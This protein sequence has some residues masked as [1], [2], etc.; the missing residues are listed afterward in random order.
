MTLVDSTLDV[1]TIRRDF[2]V[3]THPKNEGL[4]YLDSAATTQKPDVVIEAMNDF[5]R[6]YN[7]NTHRG[8]YDMAERATN[9]FEGARSK[10]AKFIH[11]PSNEQIIFTRGTTE[12]INLVA[13]GWADLHV[14]EGDR[15]VISEME[16]HSNI[17]PWQMV[18]KRRGAELVYW[19]FE[20]DGTLDV[21]KLSDLLTDRTRL[22]SVTQISNALGTI[23]PLPEIIALAHEKGVPVAVDGAQGVAHQPVDVQGLDVDFY[24]FSGHKMVGPTGI[25]VLYA[26]KERLNEMQPVMFGGDM[27]ESVDYQESTWNELPYR[28]EGG[29]QNIAGAIGLGAAIDYLSAIGLEVIRDYEAELTRYALQ[30]LQDIDD[31]RI[32]G[33]LENR[34]AAISFTLGQIHA[35]DLATWLDQKKIAIRSGHHCAQLVMKRFRVPATARASLYLYNS[36]PDIDRLVD[37]L[38]EAK[39]YFSK[40]F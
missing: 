21:N 3:L 22:L 26:K 37:A 38:K 23:N 36:K 13:Y 31:L 40:W 8:A 24:A 5:Y 15:I 18:A 25:G 30:R 2:P 4:V 20:D 29:T 6:Q 14:N 19:R 7:A 39:E 35:H 27:I 10:V 16:H 17:V 34:G 28:F 11:A 32:F 9:A 12:S 1:D 33:P